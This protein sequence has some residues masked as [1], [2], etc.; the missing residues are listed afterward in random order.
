[1]QISILV[2]LYLA[3]CF[4]SYVLDRWAVK[5]LF[6]NWAKSDRVNAIAYSVL[7]WASVLAG[8]IT[9]SIMQKNDNPAK[10]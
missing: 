7:S 9:I 6:G 2:I 8:L 5:R 1:M 10:W 3:G 4:V